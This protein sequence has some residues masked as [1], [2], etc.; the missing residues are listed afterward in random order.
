MD[1]AIEGFFLAFPQIQD[2]IFEFLQGV[3]LNAEW[4]NSFLLRV[5]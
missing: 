1:Q 2:E 3:N 5:I 4:K